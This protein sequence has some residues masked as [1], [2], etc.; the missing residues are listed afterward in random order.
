M[1][2]TGKQA[3]DFS[4]GVSADDN[5]GI[6]GYD[7][8][9]GPNGQA[10]YW[11]PTLEDACRTLLRHYDHTYVVPGER[12]PRRATTRDPV[13]RDVRTSPHVAVGDSGLHTVG[14]IF[15]AELNP[16]R[17][18]PFDI[19]SV[20]RSV[21]D[22]DSDPLERWNAWR[23]GE[24]A[25]VWDAHVGGVPVCLLGLE[26]RT[27][28]RRGYVPADGPIVVDIGHPL[29]AVRAQ[30]GAGDQR[31]QWQPAARR[32]RQP[33][34]VRRVPGVDAALAARVRRRD[35]PCGHELRRARSCSW[36]S[37]ATTAVRSWC[38]PRGSTR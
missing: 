6:G 11:A 3:L 27:L 9:M 29:P 4:G 28:A 23:G 25:V 8:V 35:R 32:A 37:P 12:F 16:E 18:K 17:K 10:Q 24:T 7:R 22:A 1:V 33:V 36:S 19:R 5:L 21:V 38:S 31:G 26:S 20:M 30:G 2:L 14:D 34:G 13:D 15:S